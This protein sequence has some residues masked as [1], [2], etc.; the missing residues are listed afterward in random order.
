MN[1]TQ[2]T[3][4]STPH[5]YFGHSPEFLL[6]AAAVAVLASVGVACVIKSGFPD[7]PSDFMEH[8][9]W[10]AVQAVKRAGFDC[11]NPAYFDHKYSKTYN[12]L[13]YVLKCESGTYEVSLETE[14]RYGEVTLQSSQ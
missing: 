11:K 13:R 4:A 3:G 9:K 5:F 8:A 7:D 1:L 6:F 14:G 12:S 2:R 10:D